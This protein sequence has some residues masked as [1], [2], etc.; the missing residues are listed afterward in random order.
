MR[1]NIFAA[2]AALL[3][4]A[5][6]GDDGP[7]APTAGDA[8]VADPPVLDQ[9]DRFP[10]LSTL[11]RTNVT[12]DLNQLLHFNMPAETGYVYT[13]RFDAIMGFPGS[14]RVAYTKHKDEVTWT[15]GLP[16]IDGKP[17]TT[18][19][20]SMG[21]AEFPGLIRFGRLGGQPL[22]IFGTVSL[23]FAGNACVREV[24]EGFLDR[25]LP[26][27]RRFVRNAIERQTLINYADFE[28]NVQPHVDQ[29][30][31][32]LKRQDVDFG[33]VVGCGGVVL[34][35][36]LDQ[37]VGTGV[38]LGF[39]V[40]PAR[41]NGVP[42]LENPVTRTIGQPNVIFRIAI[43]GRTRDAGPIDFGNRISGT[44]SIR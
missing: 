23:A 15:V 20:D 25:R 7:S 1:I 13:V 19:P 28:T 21:K 10:D 37:L 18:L 31:A 35:K 24:I 44:Y 22:H 12:V 36:K 30:M 43:P 40:N 38:L 2:F 4:T 3:L 6:A 5:C 32:A 11:A 42:G 27:I 33:S 17:F 16:A 26:D 8:P 14:T 29:L 41:A 39:A 9:T 34:G